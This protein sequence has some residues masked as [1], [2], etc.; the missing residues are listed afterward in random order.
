MLDSIW[1]TK[2]LS[3]HSNRLRIKGFSNPVKC[4]FFFMTESGKPLIMDLGRVLVF[5]CPQESLSCLRHS[6]PEVSQI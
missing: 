6:P 1:L 2:F 4:I 5:S 3:S